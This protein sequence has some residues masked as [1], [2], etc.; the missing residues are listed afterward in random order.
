MCSPRGTKRRAHQQHGV[1]DLKDLDEEIIEQHTLAE[2]SQP[3]RRTKE[4]I[5]N[6][7]RKSQGRKR[8]IEKCDA[9]RV[10]WHTPHLWRQIEAAQKKVGWSATA[11]KK[12]LEGRDRAIFCHLRR[13]TLQGWIVKTDEHG[14]PCKPRWSDAALRMNALGNHPGEGNKGGCRGALASHSDVVEVITKRLKAL[15][16]ASVP[17]TLVTVRGIVVATILRMQPDIFETQYA[18]GSYFC[19]LDSFLR[20]RFCMQI[21][22]GQ[23]TVQRMQPRKFPLTGSSNASE[24]TS[25]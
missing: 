11:M 16:D 21:S 23:N 9:T 13:S 7:S 4:V 24:L 19:Y 5:K 1:A 22:A 2:E 20:A 14:V 8:T 15:S 18:D 17:I 12:E 6:R 10:N 25:G 3:K